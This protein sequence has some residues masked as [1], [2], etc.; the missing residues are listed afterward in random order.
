VDQ[1]AGSNE[2]LHEAIYCAPPGSVIVAATGD[3]AYGYWGDLMSRAAVARGLAGVVLLGGIRDLDA[4]EALVFPVFASA[5][6]VRGT[7]K[8]HGVTEPAGSVL[9][10]DVKIRRGDLVV[11]DREGVVVLPGVP[12]EV[13][14]DT[15]VRAEA[16]EAREAAFR[17]R[18]DRGERL[19]DLI[20][21]GSA[22][23]D[24]G[25]NA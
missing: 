20:R 24:S 14:R 4:I 12:G 3:E 19:L 9:F 16:R 6:C 2:R 18:L 23:G 13:A 11:G 15:I 5:V 7:R 10:D 17:D 1:P 22:S 8:R 25:A 21:S